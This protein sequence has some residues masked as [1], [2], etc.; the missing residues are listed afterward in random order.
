LEIK[1]EKQKCPWRG[2]RDV[3]VGLGIGRCSL[4]TSSFLPPEIRRSQ[5]SG[6]AVPLDGKIPHL[7]AASI[8]PGSLRARM[9]C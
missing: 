8:L 9:H 5:C 4:V 6:Q 3:E 7:L 2:R 1:N